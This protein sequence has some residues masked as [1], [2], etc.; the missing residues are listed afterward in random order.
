MIE[1]GRKGLLKH[2]KKWMR[3]LIQREMSN[4]LRRMK[5]AQVPNEMTHLIA[6]TTH[7]PAYH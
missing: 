6:A 2:C 3:G 1:T 4:Q 5:S 7:N